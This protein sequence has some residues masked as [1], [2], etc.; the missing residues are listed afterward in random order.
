MWI[1]NDF[2]H[3]LVLF[4]FYKIRSLKNV[5][6]WKIL[7]LLGEIQLWRLCGNLYLRYKIKWGKQYTPLCIGHDQKIGRKYLYQT[8]A[9]FRVKGSKTIFFLLKISFNITLLCFTA[10]QDLKNASD[11]HVSPSSMWWWHYRE[12]NSSDAA[13]TSHPVTQRLVR[14]IYMFQPITITVTYAKPSEGRAFFSL[15]LY[16]QHWA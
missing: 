7:F 9:S 10:K 14:F 1:M 15:A 2:L 12:R 6:Y 16:P 13:T 8:I 4:F 3:F 5:H 11:K